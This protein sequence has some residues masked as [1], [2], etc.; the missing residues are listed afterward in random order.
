M[1]IKIALI[2][3]LMAVNIASAED[4]SKDITPFFEQI[5]GVMNSRDSNSIK[6]FYQYYAKPS[7]TF[8]KQSFY[9]DPENQDKIIDQETLNMNRSQYIKYLADILYTPNRYAYEYKIQSTSYD[10]KTKTFLAL[11]D[12][13]ESY[14][15][16]YYDNKSQSNTNIIVFTA[17]SCNFSLIYQNAAI[18]IAGMNCV[19]KIRKIGV[20]E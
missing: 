1:K 2:A 14:S 17:S 8:I 6:R 11:V 10:Q 5:A 20:N 9:V 13:N 7:A 18:T 12:I 16:S 3:L 19:E 15:R 4:I